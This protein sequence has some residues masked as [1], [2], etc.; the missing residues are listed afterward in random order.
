M[1]RLTRP[2]RRANHS[3]S[4]TWRRDG[5]WQ[6]RITLPDGRR[7][8][9]YA[10]SEDEAEA[11]LARLRADLARG[12]LADPGTL[13]VADLAERWLSDIRHTRA[14]GTLRSYE[15]QARRYILPA[16]GTVRLSRLGPRHAHL[17]VEYAREVGLA[18]SSIRTLQTTT[19]AMFNF[20]IDLGVIAHNPME[21]MKL[22]RLGR[23]K[24]PIES[25]EQIAALVEQLSMSRYRTAFM[26]GLGLGLRIGEVCGLRWQDVDLD[27]GIVRIRHSVET[28]GGVVTFGDLK[29]PSARRDLP[30]PSFIVSALKAERVAQAGRR[31]RHG[32]EWEDYDLVCSTY[33]GR[34]IDGKSL[35]KNLRACCDAAGVPRITFH[36]LRHLCGSI[37][38]AE[39][40]PVK[41]AQ[42]ILGHASSSTTLDIYTH[43]R[44]DLLREAAEAMDRLFG[45][46]PA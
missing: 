3:G 30:L 37:L 25:A 21:R 31:L 17:V 12:A 32:H 26:L 42:Q 40:V 4:I 5:R 27:A 19:R 9:Y 20:G 18:E 6:V 15:G 39:G 24:L 41:I 23:R 14:P 29:S 13:T 38:A 2:G 28:R 7:R 45:R 34:P 44:P 11:L 22:A 8:S 36:H 35:R 16:I 33:R 46:S 10:P 1:A 43:G